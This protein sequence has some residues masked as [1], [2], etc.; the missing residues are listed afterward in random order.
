VLR[1]ALASAIYLCAALGCRAPAPEQP[2]AAAAEF[3]REPP[4]LPENEAGVIGG[5]IDPSKFVFEPVDDD[6]TPPPILEGIPELSS[7]IHDAIVPYL[8]ARRVRLAHVTSDGSRMLV[9]TRGARSTQVFESERPLGPLTQ[10]TFGADPVMQV[11][12]LPGPVEALVVRRDRG[13]NEDHQIYLHELASGS[14][15]LLTD[16]V[17]R[18]GPFRSFNG[19]GAPLLAFTGNARAEPD[20]DVYLSNLEPPPT[21][22]LV[23]DGQW[24][25]LGWATDGQHLLVRRFWSIERS[26]IYLADLATGAVEPLV[27]DL[28]EAAFID[29]R[30]NAKGELDVLSDFG[31]EFVA[32]HTR[33][34]D[35]SWR[36]STPELAADVEAFVR[37]NG[38]LVYAVNDEGVS[39][40]FVLDQLDQLDRAPRELPLP[41]A[42]VLAGLRSLGSKRLAFTLTSA[43]LPSDAYTLEVERGELVRWTVSD[44]G[45]EPLDFVEATR[46]RAPSSDGLEVPLIV[47][48]P[49]GEGPFPA[50]LWMH[51]GPEEQARP[52]FN[53]IIQYFVDRGVAVIAPNVRGSDGYGRRYRSLD[54]GVLRQGAIEDVGAVLEWLETR[55]DIDTERVG[56]YGASYGGFM[57]LASLAAYPDRFVAGCDVVGI[58]NLVTFLEN[59]RGYRQALRRP[60]YGDERDP[61]VRAFMER[62]SP[63]HNVDRI[64]APLFVAHGAN[65]PRV[66]VSEA[67]QIV[68]ALRARGREVW[69]MLAPTE[70]H[71]FKQ[72]IN[73]DTFYVAMAMFFERHLLGAPETPTVE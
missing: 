38:A 19:A 61:E 12:R 20:L 55:G 59:T 48:R 56:I 43:T 24:I 1:R 30:F 46:E 70:G 18:H 44:P 21:L 7:A 35:G 53:P 11:S 27:V 5:P 66:P 25:V 73:R 4:P 31:G 8:E 71:A 17:S 10:L 28:D 37:L 39:R 64:Q 40:L 65:D 34:A 69:F 45:G 52:E 36:R 42:A 72:K 62:I 50:L 41:N 47:Y 29:A 6:D 63:I 49:R 13:G 2:S 51:G 9:L 58:A 16:G 54:N 23:R 3:P 32:V 57:V 67:E 15:L 26:M 14:E 22:A 60:E 33:A 68:E